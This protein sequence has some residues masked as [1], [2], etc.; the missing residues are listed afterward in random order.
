MLETE[1]GSA[2]FH[3]SRTR[4]GRGYGSVV[5][6]TR[7]WMNVM[8]VNGSDRTFRAF[9]KEPPVYIN[10]RMGLRGCPNVVTKRKNTEYIYCVT[11][12]LYL[13]YEWGT[14]FM[15]F[16]WRTTPRCGTCR[17]ERLRC[18]SIIYFLVWVEEIIVSLSHLLAQFTAYTINILGTARLV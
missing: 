6:Q 3:L 11:T 9:D 1:S 4:F 10:S 12:G 5:R 8:R 18:W 17:R 14:W 15:C 2:R 13:T 16:L 7:Q